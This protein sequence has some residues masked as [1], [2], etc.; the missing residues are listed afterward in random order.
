MS[1]F[2]ADFKLDQKAFKEAT[3]SVEA[4]MEN[5]VD[6]LALETSVLAQSSGWCP[7]D[8][9]AT[10]D[11]H[12]VEFFKRGVRL[13]YNTDYALEIHED[14]SKKL[15]TGKKRWL[16]QALVASSLKLGFRGDINE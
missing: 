7:V 9:G 6:H 2:K 8:T 12:K 3:K 13:S 15:V 11:S 16:T 1:T 14:F 5:K 4:I 10:R